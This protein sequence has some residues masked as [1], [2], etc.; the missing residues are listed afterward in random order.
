MWAL[1]SRGYA[2]LQINFRGSGGYGSD[3][4]RSGYRQWGRK[5]QDDVTDATLWAIN[6]GVADP[7]RICIYGGSYGGYAS[8]QAVVREPDLYKRAIGVVGVY[9]LPLMWKKSDGRTYAR[10]AS[11][12]WLDEFI[13]KD[14]TEL[15]AYSPAFNVDRIKANLFIIHGSKDKRVPIDH[16][17]LLARQLDAID[18]PY[19]WMVR[20]E[21]HCF[22]QVKN[23][24]DQFNAIF[25]FLD[26]NI[27]EPGMR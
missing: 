14:E 1:A 27:G 25:E 16:A 11:N 21:G 20:A 15:E 24:V 5:M 13:G 4:E 19:E 8:L 6:E 22:T 23:R 9:S 3:F 2:V 26:R 10:E 7:G 17:E 12:A 18:K